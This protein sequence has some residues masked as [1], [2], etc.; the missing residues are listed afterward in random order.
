MASYKLLRRTR[1]WCFKFAT[2]LNTKL[3]NDNYY[4]VPTA[5]ETM[6][7]WAPDS[8]KFLKDL[9]SRVSEA[10]GEKRAK[11]FLFQSLSMNLQRGHA[12]CVM[13][14]VAHH[15]K[16]EEIYILGTISTQEE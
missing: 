13:G 8:L 3:G 2:G 1:G 9:G 6:G 11:S 10:T 7:S 4:V 15:R 5:H 16:L 14:T 12:L